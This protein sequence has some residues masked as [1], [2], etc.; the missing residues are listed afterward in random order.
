MENISYT[1]TGIE[2]RERTDEVIS[3]LTTIWERSVR[4]SHDFLKE[5]DI[6]ALMPFVQEGLKQ[7]RILIIAIEKDQYIGFMGIQDQKIEMLFLSPAYF[8]QGL[9]RQF[10]E[11]AIHTYKA[12][13]VDVNEQNTQALHFY[14]HLG[15]E[16][17]QRDETDEQGNPFPILRMKLKESR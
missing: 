7:I 8:G 1:F 13:Y 2:L 15:F 10:I 9:G 12:H 6:S 14:E 5:E 17:F 4:A 16:A 11:L 3:S